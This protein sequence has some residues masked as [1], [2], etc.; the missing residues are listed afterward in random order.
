MPVLLLK[1][2]GLVKTVRFKDAKYLGD[3]I[4]AVKI[5]NDK[6][7]DELVLL[8][9]TATPS[10]RE[11]RFEVIADIVS[12][13]FMPLAY[14]GGVRSVEHA[15]R[16]LSIGVEKVVLN[17]HALRTPSLVT[18]ISSKFGASTVVV[19]I[20]VKRHGR[21]H[22]VWSDCGSRDTKRHPAE[23]AAEAESLG[24]GEIFV[25]AIDRDGTMSGYD[26]TLLRDVSRAVRVPVIASGG[27]G[28]V[29][30][31]GRAVHEGGASACAAGSFFVF[32]GSH[33]AVLISFPD[34]HELDAAFSMKGPACHW[35]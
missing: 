30:D 23:W 21:R 18:D 8:D 3:P 35:S 1:N 27:A 9:I 14:G 7:V 16:L 13:A 4:N 6:E 2:D 32:H 34:Q 25:N 10:G 15:T 31:F 28:R 12:E 20:D 26:L 29:G 22:H 5:F 11:P 19:S 33:R 17:T 24:A